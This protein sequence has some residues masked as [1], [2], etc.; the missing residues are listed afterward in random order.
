M[1]VCHVWYTV[2]YSSPCTLGVV[3]SNLR[4]SSR[5]YTDTRNILKP[6]C[7]R[8][9]IPLHI[10][11]QQITAATYRYSCTREQVLH[12][13]GVCLIGLS[14]SL[15]AT[16]MYSRCR[17]SCHFWPSQTLPQRLATRP[18]IRPSKWWWDRSRVKNAPFCFANPLL[19]TEQAPRH[20]WQC[21]K[22]HC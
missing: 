8:V 22:N 14:L 1:Y 11:V 20:L 16:P 15:S 6:V 19:Q 18:T 21:S 13:F 3:S 9:C 17:V 10:T 5:N 2:H 4:N 12:F 7:T